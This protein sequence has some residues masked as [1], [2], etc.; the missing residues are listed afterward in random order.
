[1]PK[2]AVGRLLRQKSFWLFVLFAWS[3]LIARFLFGQVRPME[4]LTRYGIT[5][6]AADLRTIL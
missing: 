5:V 6:S 4:K 3:F 1:M 2:L